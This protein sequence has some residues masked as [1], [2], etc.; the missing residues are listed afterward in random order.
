MRDLIVERWPIRDITSNLDF[1][2]DENSQQFSIIDNT[3]KL[4]KGEGMIENGSF[5]Q[6]N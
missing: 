2:K 3:R 5:I 1:P 4:L 6:R